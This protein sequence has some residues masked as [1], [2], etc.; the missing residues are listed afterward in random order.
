[1]DRNRAAVCVR[2]FFPPNKGTKSVLLVRS[3]LIGSGCLASNRIRNLNHINHSIIQKLQKIIAI[4]VFLSFQAKQIQIS[5]RIR[6]WRIIRIRPWR[7]IRNR[8]ERIIRIRPW[9]IIQ[10]RPWRN[11]RI[12]LWK[13]DRIR[14]PFPRRVG[15]DPEPTTK[16]YTIFLKCF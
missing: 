11:I 14:I 1:M 10:I 8:P 3:V 15:P 13:V 16:S 6:P 9:R 4:N 12:Q 2:Y 5:Y 7:L